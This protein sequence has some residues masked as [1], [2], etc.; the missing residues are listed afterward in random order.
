[1]TSLP[2][3]YHG[4]YLRIDLTAQSFAAV[5][6]PESVLRKYIGGTGL[7]TWLLLGENEGE[8]DPL[9]TSA[10]LIFVFSPLVGSPITTS[11]KFAVVAKSP[12]TNRINDSLASSRFAING[13]KTGYDAF[14]IVGKSSQPTVLEIQPENVRFHHAQN[15]WGKTIPQTEEILQSQ[16]GTDHDFAVIGPAGENLVHFATISH[17]R[18]HAG[19]GGMGAV[20]GSKFL[21]AISICGDRLVTFHDKQRLV[22]YSK[23][24]SKKSMGPA[25][26][27]YRELGTIG[28][29]LTFNRLGTLPTRNFQSST[30][31]NIAA[32]SPESKPDKFQ[33]TQATCAACTIGCEHLFQLS[34]TKKPVRLEYENV[35]ALGPMC[36]IS[37]PQTVLDASQICDVLG[38][39]TISTGVTIAFAMECAE[40]GLWKN[41][42]L[43]FGD[44]KQLLKV[45]GDI[46]YRRNLGKILSCGSRHLAASLGEEATS[47]APHV[48][49]LELPGYE[50]RAL[51]TMALGFAVGARGAD[52]NRSGAYQVDFSQDV[53]SEKI[54]KAEVEKAI[55]IEDESVLMDSLIL[56]KFLRGVF[57]D[58]ISAM[59]ETLQMV[60]GWEISV[61]ELVDVACRIV[62]AKK[63]FNILQGWSPEEDTLPERFFTEPISDGPHR[64]AVLNK[65]HFSK[66]ISFYNRSRGW[67]ESGWVS[68]N[69]LQDMELELSSV[70][71]KG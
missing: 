24:L 64:G 38:M 52:H 26:A 4:R 54:G 56:C 45:L 9:G 34:D 35:F 44:G 15:L 67:D 65:E 30:F 20:M 6:I 8:F 68:E 60:T 55:R 19:R 18:R 69:Q 43:K 49:G 71:E 17:N 50:P 13:K 29:L 21:K 16:F 70:C 27:K 23:N 12:L 57:D 31:E 61:S 3:G 46:G 59:A 42:D 10:P 28:N 66:L 41:C 47:L 33:E 11:A 7:G 2:G 40:K 63:Q 14:I 36:G 48:K 58:K 53:N 32:V 25:T 37:D 39:D 1:M 5:P 62:N 51:Q 22:E